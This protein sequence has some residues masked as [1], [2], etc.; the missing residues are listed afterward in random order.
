[1]KKSSILRTLLV[2]SVMFSAFPVVAGDDVES[3]VKDGRFFGEVRYRYE[4]VEQ[5]GISNNANVSTIRTNVGF[6]TGEYKNFQALIEGQL[7][8]NIGPNEYN[9]TTNGKTTYPVVADPNVAEINELW[10]TYSGIKDTIFKVG[11]QKVNLDNQ[12]F[13]GTVNWRQ[14]DQ[15]YDAAAIINSS[16]PDLNLMYAYVSNINRINGGDHALGDLDTKTHLVHANYKVANWLDLTGYGYWLNIKLAPTLSSKTFGVRATGSV[17][18]N[19]DWSVFYE[20]E[21]AKQSDNGNNTNNYDE[22]YYHISPEIKGKGFTFQVGYEE[23]GGNGTTSFQ[24]PLATGHKFNGWADKFLT[25]PNQ[26]LQDAYVSGSYK[27]NGTNSMLDGTKFTAVYHKFDGDSSG[28]FGSEI[29]LAVGRKFTLPDAGQPFKDIDI[30]LK[31]AD[32]NADDTA[33]TDTQKI[34]VQIGVKF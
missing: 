10:V 11:R 27:A 1:M 4:N 34:W 26:G 28:D 8:N 7:V 19:D 25:I 12:R 22:N 3:I 15:T 30:L 32:Y 24:T 5:D 20:A 33:Y 13:I 17:P 21:M 29:D 31:F 9:S 18:L 2:S 14:N 16:I 23:L 6:K